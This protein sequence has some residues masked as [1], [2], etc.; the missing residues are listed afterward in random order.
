MA[1][2]LCEFRFR[3]TLVLTQPRMENFVTDLDFASSMPQTADDI[4]KSLALVARRLSTKQHATANTFT[5]VLIKEIQYKSTR[6]R[7]YSIAVSTIL[8]T[9]GLGAHTTAWK[10]NSRLLAMDEHLK[11]C[12]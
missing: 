3:I 1:R 5:R 10:F 9:L 6:L 11:M 2:G 12:S 4:N 8:A 7:E